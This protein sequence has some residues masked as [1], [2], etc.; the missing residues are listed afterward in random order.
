LEI[1]DHI[2]RLFVRYGD[3]PKLDYHGLPAFSSEFDVA[4]PQNFWEK[5]QTEQCIVLLGEPGIGKS[6][7]FEFQ[8]EGLKNSG[9][10]CFLIRLKD[11]YPGCALD[12]LI[13]ADDNES[14][15]NWKKDPAVK[16]FLFLDSLDE[17]R[18]DYGP[19]LKQIVAQVSSA[20]P[21]SRLQMRLSCRVRDWRSLSDKSQLNRIFRDRV[22]APGE[23]QEGVTVL[24][25][26]PLHYG[27][28]HFI[29][30]KT[31]VDPVSFISKAEQ[32]RVLHLCSHP[33]LLEFLLKEYKEKAELASTGTDAYSKAI[34]RLLLEENP[35]HG[36]ARKS[37]DPGKRRSVAS[38]LASL[39]V[40]S[41]QDCLHVPDMDNPAQPCI[42]S[43]LSGE[44]KGILLETLNTKAFT[45][46]RPGEFRFF[47]RTVA[48]FLAAEIMSNKIA[49][50][51]TFLHLCPLLF[52]VNQGVPT[53]LRGTVSWLAGLNKRA[54]EECLKFDPLVVLEGDLS[55]YDR[56]SKE[57]I[58]KYLAQRFRGRKWQ[59]EVTSYGELASGVDISLLIDLIG[60]HH[61]EAV[62]TMA[63]HMILEGRA[64][65]AL[66][67]VLEIAFDDTD[68]EIIRV[69]SAM[70]LAEQGNEEQKKALK[71]FLSRCGNSD[72][73]DEMT[74][75]IL[76]GLFPHSLTVEEALN[77]L[78]DHPAIPN[79]V[80]R[81]HMF[82]H[83]YF[84]REIANKDLERAIELLFEKIITKD[85]K[86]WD[87][88]QNQHL[89]ELF[90]RL[91]SQF[92]CSTVDLS[93]KTIG[94]WLKLLAES[95]MIRHAS[96]DGALKRIE[97]WLQGKDYVKRELFILQL[98]RNPPSATHRFSLWQHLPFPQGSVTPDDFDWA[99][100]LFEQDSDDWRKHAFFQIA[101]LAWSKGNYLPPARMTEL[102]RLLEHC[103]PCDEEWQRWRSCPLEY[104]KWKLE[105]REFEEKNRIQREQNRAQA[106]ESI[107]LIEE[108]DLNW[109]AFFSSFITDKDT[110]LFGPPN[111]S[112]LEEEYG[113]DVRNAAE[114]GYT[115]AWHNASIQLSGEEWE[116]N[117]VPWYDV[118]ISH[119]LEAQ[120]QKG[121]IDWTTA[122]SEQ[123]QVAVYLAVKHYDSLPE[124]FV[125]L[126]CERKNLVEEF[127]G[128]ILAIEAESKLEHLRLCS[129]FVYSKVLNNEF[130]EYTTVYLLSHELPA[131]QSALDSLLTS[132]MGSRDTGLCE[133][134]AKHAV[135]LWDSIQK[136]DSKDQLVRAMSLLVAWWYVDWLS[137]WQFM[138]SKVFVGSNRIQNILSF[139]GAMMRILGKPGFSLKSWP[140][141]MPMDSAIAIVP[142]LYE[143]IPPSA[144]TPVQGF[145]G[146][147]DSLKWFRDGVLNV[148]RSGQPQEARKAFA[149][150]VTDPLFAEHKE[151]FLSIL[152]ELNRRIIDEQW[153]PASPSFV[154]QVIFNGVNLIRNQSDLFTL[155]IDLLDTEIRAALVSDTSLV[156]LLW[157]GTKTAG[158]TPRDE[159]PL[160]AVL[161]NQLSLLLKGR[162][163]VFAREPE[164]FDAKKPD[165]RVSASIPDL[166]FVHVPIE[167]KQAHAADVWSSP[168]SQ[169]FEKYMKEPSINSGLYLVG[170]YGL[171]HSPPVQPTTGEK[172]TNLNEF[173]EALQAYI[174]IALAEEE[175]KIAVFV[176][177]LQ[178]A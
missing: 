2:P 133:V 31:G 83:V 82:W 161:A 80:G 54:R 64:A 178:V 116:S 68:D 29:A 154:A 86:Y 105:R 104:G 142:Y 171:P 174:D 4:V 150:W 138:T 3:L 55:A 87:D 112:I 17:A 47:H 70:I 152:G 36:E 61:A 5:W 119:A 1:K 136:Q 140:A 106:S 16:G 147:R 102:I 50:G 113:A 170:W 125:R 123:V 53:P 166:G 10:Y 48:E 175:R 40:L 73:E 145:L 98:E 49:G 58:I 24:E 66:D 107:N 37:S 96:D 23:R 148:V 103:A 130:M 44:T 9:E 33:L 59:R 115:L 132:A 109:L 101:T 45:S 169:L 35:E 92:L 162:P 149:E 41:G 63:L 167:V 121:L 157:K 51:M 100:Q 137:A 141:D 71:V 78:H 20:L 94:P 164:V 85:V 69:I 118:L 153:Q 158:R 12:E 127:F 114:N 7:E 13:D 46:S 19:A 77:T 117:K 11:L 173:Q 18:L 32:H 30:E 52:A 168:I 89:A 176:F 144:D 139:A 38:K 151:G 91:L 110:G 108:G 160:Q 88:Y 99:I 163:T 34:D 129:K 72:F 25:L 146:E 93:P 65:P 134:V 39:C 177:D 57:F 79:H 81:Y 128:K 67:R 76:S 21:I 122:S 26:L 15:K 159:K 22:N 42:D 62:R 124:W 120:W 84:E 155:L 75:A 8:Y 135:D 131:N 74:G 156:P 126:Y 90:S 143:A 172:F 60:K 97:D 6:T 111:F 165:F 27:G 95:N 28:I 14:W 56:H 43:C